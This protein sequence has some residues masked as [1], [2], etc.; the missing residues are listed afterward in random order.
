M[1][2]PGVRR[3]LRGYSR[4][5]KMVLDVDLNDTPPSE[6]RG[7]EE[8]ISEQAGS[9]PPVNGR[10]PAAP[11]VLEDIDDEVVIS[12]PRS[13]LEARNQSRRNHAEMVVLD[14]DS[15]THQGANAEEPI[16]RLSLNSHNKRGRIPPNRTVINCEYINL[17]VSLSAKRRNTKKPIPEPE[18]VAPPPPP[19]EPTFS[20][21]V[22]MGALVEETSTTCGHI[23]CKKCITAAITAQ[24]KCPT[25]RG[26]LSM[27]SIHRVYLPTTS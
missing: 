9:L 17:E 16:T 8:Q 1:S 20:C 11:I 2:T 12:S 3:P 27:K 23:F 21:A 22:C 10:V 13:F 5:R 19:K 4:R 15:Y 18:R 7:L 6:N 25:C 26:K 14:E 24:K